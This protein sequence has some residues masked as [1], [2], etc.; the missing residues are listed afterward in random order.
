MRKVGFFTTIAVFSMFFMGL[1]VREARAYDSVDL[2][3]VIPGASLYLIHEKESAIEALSVRGSEYQLGLAIARFKTE[4]IREIYANRYYCFTET[5]LIELGRMADAMRNDAREVLRGLMDGFHEMGYFPDRRIV[6]T[7]MALLGIQSAHPF[8]ALFRCPDPDGPAT[9][10]GALK[11]MA[12]GTDTTKPTKNPAFDSHAAT[13]WGRYLEHTDVPDGV[14]VSGFPDW[15][16]V[17]FPGPNTENPNSLLVR[18]RLLLHVKPDIGIPYTVFTMA[19]SI[20]P[21]STGINAEGI[22]V[23]GTASG[24]PITAIEAMEPQEC[25][26]PFLL[27]WCILKDTQNNPDTFFRVN[28]LI[29]KNPIRFFIAQITRNNATDPVRIWETSGPDIPGYPE[30]TMRAG[31][32]WYLRETPV[33]IIGNRALGQDGLFEGRDGMVYNL[34]GSFPLFPFTVEAS[35]Q[36]GTPIEGRFGSMLEGTYHRR[37]LGSAELFPRVELRADHLK[38]WAVRYGENDIPLPDIFNGKSP[39]P[40]VY[41]SVRKDHSGGF[42]LLSDGSF[43]GYWARRGENLF[44]YDQTG[45]LV[46]QGSV[47]DFPAGVIGACPIGEQDIEFIAYD[48]NFRL[49]DGNVADA[50]NLHWL[51]GV[52]AHLRDGNFYGPHARTHAFYAFLGQRRDLFP[53]TLLE[54]LRRTYRASAKKDGIGGPFGVGIYLLVPDGDHRMLFTVPRIEGREIR[55]GLDQSVS[56]IHIT[57]GELSSLY[58]Q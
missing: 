57:W 36:T 51:A 6:A 42:F 49:H 41:T 54:T 26:A 35:S 28:D 52:E 31:E 2:L 19:G 39:V 17:P 13:M 15:P 27:G 58:V 44:A 56:P 34:G 30:S 40:L 47:F 12:P 21:M 14:V 37:P 32:P 23:A 25:A 33:T 22:V 3:G 50:M 8:T 43:S 20:V 48:Y 55:D 11:D 53:D 1:T 46:C 45:G 5:E 16:L 38:E 18:N 10:P 29:R 4:A 9:S 7:H 24:M